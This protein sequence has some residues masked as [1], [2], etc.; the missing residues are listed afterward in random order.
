MV[1]NLVLIVDFTCGMLLGPS[2]RAGTGAGVSGSLTFG[3]N[4]CTS[5]ENS[6]APC[7]VAPSSWSPASAGSAAAAGAAGAA[8]VCSLGSRDSIVGRSTTCGWS[9]TAIVLKLVRYKTAHNAIKRKRGKLLLFFFTRSSW[10]HVSSYER[11]QRHRRRR[12]CDGFLFLRHDSCCKV[13]SKSLKSPCL[14]GYQRLW[15]KSLTELNLSRHDNHLRGKP[16]YRF[17]SY[18]HPLY[19]SCWCYWLS[20]LRWYF[21]G[22]AQW[23][24]HIYWN[25]TPHVETSFWCQ[26]KLV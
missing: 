3:T 22:S 24:K 19:A 26:A 12:C 2:P 1:S 10:C 16:S 15:N 4:V 11:F 7:G 14:K 23:N 18:L 17:S 20:H 25:K 13:T 6:A 9:A 8:V 21:T 5:M